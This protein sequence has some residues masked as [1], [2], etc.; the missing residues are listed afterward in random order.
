MTSV[1]QRPSRVAV[2][3]SGMRLKL[4]LA[5]LLM[6]A[7]PLSMLML[8]AGWFAFPFVREFYH[9]DR[10]F[11]LITTPAESTWWMFG[12]LVLTVLI[13]FLGGLYLAIKIVQPIIQLSRHATRMAQGDYEHAAQGGQ[14]GELDDLTWSLNQLTSRIR[15]DMTE[16]KRFGERSS[17]INLDIHKRVVMFSGL[18]QIGEL[19][20]TGGQLDVVLD[21]V[22]EKLAML[23]DQAFSFC[24]LQP[25]DGVPVRLRRT[26]GLDLELLG[27]A[28]FESAAIVDAAHPPAAPL[29]PAWEHLG[30]PNLLV[31]P[32]MVRKQ[33]IG[34]LGIGNRKASYQWGQEL[35]DV[36]GIFAKQA[37]LAI[38]NE[39]LQRQAKSLAIYDELTGV[40]NEAYMRQRLAEEIQRA[41]LYQRPCA[42]A[43]FRVQDLADYRRRHGD[44]EA[45]RALKR[46]TRLVQECVTEVDRV[47]RFNGNVLAVIL[48]ECN[49]RQA[50]TL[51]EQ[52]R[53]R[54]EQ[55]FAGSADPSDRLELR[56]S[57]SENPVDGSTAEELIA[58]ASNEVR[59]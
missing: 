54:A 2:A 26:N 34:F 22:T 53:Q 51:M 36:M 30:R 25:L 21:L 33:L 47:G 20:S 49:K 55:A 57:I 10:W 52:I 13:T 42:L 6:S 27:P 29:Q 1:P 15:D 18:L 38:E 50:A 9:L 41:V 45:E 59:G 17:Q 5:F 44:P 56:G 28:V 40:Y 37:G 19:I 48:P 14:G 11:P 58:K 35:G 3:P 16:L 8:V 23:D 24:C 43:M 39:L 31:Q 46:I 32:V 7:V 4:L 12:L